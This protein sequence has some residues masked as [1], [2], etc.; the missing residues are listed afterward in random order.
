MI[1]EIRKRRIPIVGDGKGVWSFIHIDDAAQATLRALEHGSTGVYNIVD[2]EPAPV[3]EWLPALAE[4]VG[5]KPPFRIPSWVGRLA[6]G[7]HGVVMMTRCGA[8]RTPRRSG[9]LR[10]QPQWPTWRE[11]FRRGLSAA[12]P[13]PHSV[14]QRL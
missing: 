6:I 3:S 7:E 14:L 2:D 11:G 8:P 10:W 5:A 1:S 13:T 4:A 9:N 12:T